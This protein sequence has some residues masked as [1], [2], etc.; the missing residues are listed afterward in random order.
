MDLGLLIPLQV[1]YKMKGIFYCRLLNSVL[2]FCVI[3]LAF[4][5]VE[6]VQVMSGVTITLASAFCMQGHLYY[7]LSLHLP[8]VC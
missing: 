4:D 6:F 5:S 2:E 8:F 1:I 7:S 3:L